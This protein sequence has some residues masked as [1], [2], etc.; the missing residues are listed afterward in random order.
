M[1]EEIKQDNMDLASFIDSQN[2]PEFQ[3]VF[4]G[5]QANQPLPGEVVI[6]E[7]QGPPQL[8]ENPV[9]M[10]QI[11][12]HESTQKIEKGALFHGHI[13]SWTCARTPKERLP[14]LKFDC[15]LD[16]NGWHYTHTAFIPR[17]ETGTTELIQA[18][19]D[20]I[21]E[22]Y[23]Y[24][25]EHDSDPSVDPFPGSRIFEIGVWVDDDKKEHKKVQYVY[26]DAK[27]Y[28]RCQQ[29]IWNKRQEKQEKKQPWQAPDCPLP[30]RGG[31]A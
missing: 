28:N 13:K 31:N 11:R 8:P 29:N 10:Q 23:G 24:N 4:S 26:R 1:N 14:Y 15:V 18:A 5:A 25:F 16:F 2:Q 9:R 22:R 19:Q 12:S 17:K 21:L 3:K 27:D 30:Q 6:D 7:P 20:R